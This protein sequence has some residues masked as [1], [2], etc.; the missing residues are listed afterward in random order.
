MELSQVRVKWPG[1]YTTKSFSVNQPRKRHA[2]RHDGFLHL[3]QSL[4]LFEM[5]A[6]NAP[7]IC[8]PSPPKGVCGLHVI[9]CITV[10]PFLCLNPFLH[11]FSSSSY[12]SVQVVINPWENLKR[13]NKKR[14]TTTTSAAPGLRI[15][16]KAH[17]S[18]LSL[19]VLDSLCLFR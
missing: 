4:K 11:V 18:P 14:K 9:I 7:R 5:F 12:F 16:T 10:N 19:S 17:Y 6:D 1:R 8:G 3:R 2:F 15:S 13:R